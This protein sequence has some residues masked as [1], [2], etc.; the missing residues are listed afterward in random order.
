MILGNTIISKGSSIDADATGGVTTSEEIAVAGVSG[1]A[2][3]PKDSVM[4]E[5]K[6]GD[7][8]DFTLKIRTGLKMVSRLEKCVIAITAIKL[9][10]KIAAGSSSFSIMRLLLWPNRVL[11][12][13]AKPM[14]RL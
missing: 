9:E 7:S 14:A 4:L 10:G 8:Q 3:I 5:N 12:S 2:V 1:E 6:S 13:S 11:L